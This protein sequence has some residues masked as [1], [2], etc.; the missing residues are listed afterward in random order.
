M[1]RL[2]ISAHADTGFKS[3]R[4]RRAR[5]GQHNALL[6]G[7]LDNFVGVHA[8][9]Q[10]YF[11]GRLDLP[12]VQINLTYG[13][14]S[15]DFAGAREV[16]KRLRP[17]DVVLV[18]DVTGT[19]TKADIVFENAKNANMRRLIRKYL[20]GTSYDLYVGCPDPVANQ[21]E[22]DVYRRVCPYTVFLGI[23]VLGGD[24]NRR[25]VYCRPQSIAAAAEAICRFAEGWE[26]HP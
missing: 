22:T 4:L 2:I 21:D 17:H 15:G 14:E 23:P 11:S 6:Y 8:V 1:S 12:R 19:P 20:A 24:Y 9:M 10:A 16:A 26:G 5:P 13:E 3:H 25:R 7:H 18:V